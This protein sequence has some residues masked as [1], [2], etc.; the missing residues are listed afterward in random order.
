MND[1]PKR[2]SDRERSFAKI[3]LTKHNLPGYLRDMSPTGFKAAFPINP[4][5]K[6]GDTVPL[7]I[8]TDQSTFDYLE[9]ELSVSLVWLR[10]FAPLWLAGFQIQSYVSDSS[11]DA[12]DELLK[13]FMS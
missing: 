9:M 4:Q 10:F 8:Y 5:L 13:N 3:L 11:K 7:R 12:Y 2:Q 1:E 6:V